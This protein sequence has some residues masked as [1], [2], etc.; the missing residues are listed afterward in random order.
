MEVRE[1]TDDKGGLESLKEALDKITE[2]VVHRLAN[3]GGRV[4]HVLQAV[5]RRW[6]HRIDRILNPGEPL[7]SL[8]SL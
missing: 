5:M 1:I 7:R 8:Y 6:R 4:Q 2:E 3:F